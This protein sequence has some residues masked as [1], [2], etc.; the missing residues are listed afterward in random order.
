MIHAARILSNAR[1]PLFI[2]F[3]GILLSGCGVNN[4]PTYNEDGVG[5]LSLGNGPG[6]FPRL[7]CPGTDRSEYAGG[8]FARRQRI[9]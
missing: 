2:V 3:A 8:T 4:I 1:I 5:W 7:V 9:G 6:L